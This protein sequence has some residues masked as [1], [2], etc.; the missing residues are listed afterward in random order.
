MLLPNI[1]KAKFQFDK[2]KKSLQKLKIQENCS[3]TLGYKGSYGDF[4][5]YQEKEP[6]ILDTI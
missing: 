2:I 1:N 5:L 4:C 3:S 6:D